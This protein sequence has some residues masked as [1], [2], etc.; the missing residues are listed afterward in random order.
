[1]A[2]HEI[3]MLNTLVSRQLTRL[4]RYGKLVEEQGIL[5]DSEEYEKL[6]KVLERKDKILARMDEWEKLASLA[7]A[8]GG[9]AAEQIAGSADLFARLTSRLDFFA[10]RE[11]ECLKKAAGIKEDIAG[12]LYALR[13]G[14]KLLRKYVRA[15]H[16]SKALY[17]DVKG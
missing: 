15:S 2:T 9:L 8:A 17:K 12:R 14:K 5:I 16:D 13:K 1:L 6:F 10:G 11:K 7:E 4:E 3:E